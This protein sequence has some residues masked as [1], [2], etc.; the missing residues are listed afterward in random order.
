MDREKVLEE[1]VKFL[2]EENAKLEASKL[3]LKMLIRG[4]FEELRGYTE[5]TAENAGISCLLERS[6]SNE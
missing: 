1:Q 4:L 5:N 3:R 6:M 2:R